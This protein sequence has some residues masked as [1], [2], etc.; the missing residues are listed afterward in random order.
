LAGKGHLRK[1]A[2]DWSVRLAGFGPVLVKGED[3]IAVRRHGKPLPAFPVG[4]QVILSTGDRIPLDPGETLRLADDFLSVRPQAPLSPSRGEELKVPLS[5][6]VALWLAAPD[7]DSDPA[8]QVRRLLMS[9]RRADQ[10][11]L[12]NG[13]VIEGTLLGLD[14]RT[15]C[16]VRVGSKKVAVPFDRLAAVAF[17]TELLIATFPKGTYG[18]LILDNGCR[19]NLAA[20]SVDAGSL[21]A[22]TAFGTKVSVALD[23]VAA[24]DLRQGRA[25][26]LSD[27][28]PTAYK[29]VPFLSVSWPFVRDSNVTGRELRLAGSTFDKGLGLHGES[30][31]TFEL[32]SKYEWF[33]SLVG[34]DSQTGKRGR[35]HVEV[36]VDNKVFEVGQGQELQAGKAPLAVRVNLPGARL[37]TLAVR[38]GAVGDVQAHVN[39]ADAR[40]IKAMPG[41][42]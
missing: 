1:V 31:I 4:E 16:Q 8:L 25:V 24:L 17:G 34:M 2:D 36:L 41:S 3:V 20:A 32:A 9:H 37:L 26:Y 22:S 15:D 30:R 23:H 6:V 5:R 42:N 38:P 19:L 33:E 12:R 35:A 40:L 13:D 10:V 39:W 14:R 27:L 18:Y 29:H 7:R 21:K 28:E 11:L